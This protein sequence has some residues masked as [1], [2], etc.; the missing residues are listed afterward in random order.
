MLKVV[1][2]SVYSSVAELEHCIP[3]SLTDFSTLGVWAQ[4]LTTQEV[5]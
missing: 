5:W 4:L 1:F 2:R 3:E